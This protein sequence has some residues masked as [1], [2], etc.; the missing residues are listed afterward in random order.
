ME[1]SDLVSDSVFP[2]NL[3]SALGLEPKTY[4]LKVSAE[5]IPTDTVSSRC[6][7]KTAFFLAS[8]LPL[9]PSIT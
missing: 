1:F 5:Q 9:L 2:G 4:G 6:T 3:L 8:I 7:Q